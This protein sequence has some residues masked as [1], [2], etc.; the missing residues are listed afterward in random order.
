MEEEIQ[1]IPSAEATA[2]EA[3][4]EVATVA[5]AE[6]AERTEAL[7]LAIAEI[8]GTRAELAALRTEFIAHVEGNIGDFS[9]IRERLSTLETGLAV[10]HEALEEEADELEDSLREELREEILAETSVV[11]EAAAASVEAAEA[12]EPEPVASEPEHHGRERSKRHFIR[13]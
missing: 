3:L 8:A 11:E 13:I 7:T 9:G 2:A 12:V 10:M 4:A 1:E 6:T 5:I